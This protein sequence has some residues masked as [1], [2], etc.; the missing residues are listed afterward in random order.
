MAF[1]HMNQTP[2]EEPKQAETIT[3]ETPKETTTVVPPTTTE[4]K[5][6]VPPTTEPP[7]AEPAKVDEFFE[8]FNKRY[9]TTY[10][11]DD[12]L[13]TLFGLPGKVTEYEGK[14]K[15]HEELEKSVDAYKKE[16]EETKA[17]TTSELLS[18]P[19]IRSAYIADQL[20]AK[21]PDK[22]PFMLQEIAMSDLSKMS[23]LDA[24]AKEVKINL[25]NRN[26]EDIKK[27]VLAELGVD[28]ETKPE[29]LD[30]IVGTR[31]A[32][33]GIQA[34]ENIKNLLS[35][36]TLPKTVTKEEREALQTKILEDKV[37]TVAP[38]KEIFRKFDT[39]K[40]GD[41]EF[42]VPDEFKTGLDDMFQGI[43][44][45]GGLEIN[46]KNLATAELLKKALFMEEYF[47]QM[48]AVI[49]KQAKTVVQEKTDVELHNE[50]PL[51]TATSTDQTTTEEKLP[52]LG[53][54]FQDNKHR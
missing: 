31:L 5:T 43:F 2:P 45:D 12:E 21:Y 20:Q 10:K 50:T 15:D 35:G 9:N 37:K 38:F 34:R 44:I 46:E 29:E 32:M 22:D 7:K 26:L 17:N 14:L 28:P 16:L 6:E 51:N 52:G 23:D 54:F 41:F 30:S 39:Y 48:R 40:N 8:N 36:I 18:K 33:R 1:E 49:E 42:V 13:K 25:P 47:P 4:T 24:I 53:Q 27:A 3:A 11:S 19:L